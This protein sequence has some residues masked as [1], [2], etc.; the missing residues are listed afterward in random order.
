MS[1]QAQ[2]E[3]RR[4][5]RQVDYSRPVDEWRSTVVGIMDAC[6]GG[7]SQVAAMESAI[8]YDGLRERVLGRAMGSRAQDGRTSIATEKAVKA[9]IAKLLEGEYEE[10]ERLCCE[11]IDYEV[12][13][14]SGRCM[15]YN[16]GMD[17]SE[18]R[19]ARI[20]QGETTC[21]FCIMLASRGPVY[22][23]AE[24]AG[25][26]TKYH[27]HCD[28][29]IMPV[30]G[31]YAVKTK[32][33]GTIRRGGTQYEG[34]DPDA[35][36]DQYLNQMLNP[37]HTG[38][39]AQGATGGKAATTTGRTVWKEA[40]SKGLVRFEDIHALTSYIRDATSYEDLCQRLKD[41]NK[42]IEHYGLSDKQMGHL[43]DL[44]RSV[45]ARYT[46]K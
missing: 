1:S 36:F 19:F 15:V 2:A 11:R 46:D 40:A 29:L 34:Y 5:L 4:Q 38:G 35:Y 12:T 28:C 7:A 22:H 3:L 20:P 31:S 23:T 9:F 30:W 6:C 33:G 24:T 10:F 32:A 44:C 13:V 17:P 18:P 43:Q 37:S 27:P 16:S 14:A 21:D 26:L 8:F 42:E 41:I 39:G 45:R 25:A